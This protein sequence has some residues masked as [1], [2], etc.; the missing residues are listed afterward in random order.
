VVACF[1]GP[2]RALIGRL[3]IAGKARVSLI[4]HAA[5]APR[6]VTVGSRRYALERGQQARRQRFLASAWEWELGKVQ[7]CLAALQ[8]N[9]MIDT[10]S[11]THATVITICNYDHYQGADGLTDTP[12]DTAPDTLASH[13][14]VRPE[15][16]KKEG[17]T[18]TRL[19][20]F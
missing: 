19:R 16:N 17:N 3:P 5:W 7:R 4:E 15:S 10:Q 9:T 14:R 20:G 11:D 2:I 6:T 1:P 18:L 12:D 13:D 8:A